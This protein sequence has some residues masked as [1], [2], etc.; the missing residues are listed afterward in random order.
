MQLCD[1]KEAGPS[2]EGTN[3]TNHYYG[4]TRAD[5]H[6]LPPSRNQQRRLW[7]YIGG[8]RPL[9]QIRPSLRH[10][11]QSR[12]DRSGPNL[13]WLC[14]EVRVSQTHP[15]WSGS[16]FENQLFHRLQQLSGV[17][18]ARTTPYHPQGNGKAERFNRTLLSMLRTLTTEQKANWKDHLN[19]VVHAY[20]STRSEATGYAPSFLM[21]G[22]SQ[23][24]RWSGIWIESRSTQPCKDHSSYVQKWKTA[25]SEAYTI[26]RKTSQDRAARGKELRDK[27][28]RPLPLEAGDRVLV[29]NT[30]QKPGPR[31][32]QSY[33]KR[34]S[35]W[36][37][38][39][40]LPTCRCMRSARKGDRQG[41]SAS[42]QSPVP[43]E[44]LQTQED[45]RATSQEILVDPR[46]T[47]QDKNKLMTRKKM[48]LMTTWLC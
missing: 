33:W 44:Y 3:D 37:K 47:Q 42:P 13:Q 7:I 36:W 6:R 17:Q 5:F 32:L 11:E 12:P 30:H 4:T 25:M 15:S 27:N 8:S 38:R 29:R 43:C 31:K 1:S 24:S 40:F 48:T 2:P 34:R 26:A 21:F 16:E 9:H 20:N 39:E 23:G 19:K 45:P 46:G 41:T 10:E 22:R 35:T 18:N 28:L 14:L